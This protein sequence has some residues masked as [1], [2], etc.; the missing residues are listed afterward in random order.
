[1]PSIYPPVLPLL[2][3]PEQHC[4]PIT[5]LLTI[6]HHA[7]THDETTTPHYTKITTSIIMTH[8]TLTSILIL[9]L[10][11]T[12]IA[13]T[14][15]FPLVSAADAKPNPPAWMHAA[16]VWL[17]F[18]DVVVAGLFVWIWACGYLVRKREAEWIASG[19]RSRHSLIETEMRRIGMW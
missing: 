5:I 2:P 14:N 12:L 10:I 19:G 11:L 18:Y 8:P 16:T 1:M 9:I 15:A 6:P 3:S 17:I 7:S 13:A 4:L